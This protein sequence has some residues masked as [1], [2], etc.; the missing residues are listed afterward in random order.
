MSE[1]LNLARITKGLDNE[2]DLFKV[3][4]KL[5]DITKNLLTADRS[6]IFLYDSVN[7]E[8]FTY[9]AHGV[10]EIR[11]PAKGGISGHTFSSGETL[12]IPD[13]YKDKR[14]NKESDIK[15]GYRCKTILSMPIR[16]DDEIIGVFQVINKLDKESFNNE[17]IDLL[18]KFSSY[19]A[20][21]LNR[22]LAFKKSIQV[23]RKK[24]ANIGSILEKVDEDILR[25]IEST[26]VPVLISNDPESAD[27]YFPFPGLDVEIYRVENN[28]F[29]VQKDYRN[30]VLVD[31]FRLKKD[32]PVKILYNSSITINEYAI[33]YEQIKWYFKVKL[34]PYSPLT[35]Y[36][37]SY[38]NEIIIEKEDN[39]FT[40]ARIELSRSLIKI[41]PLKEQELYINRKKTA[42][43][44]YV[45]INDLISFNGK[46]LNLKKLIYEEL[47]EKEFL[48]FD[49]SQ[50]KF[51]ISNSTKAD[52]SLSDNLGIVWEGKLFK[53]D[54]E[55]YFDSGNCPFDIYVN[56]HKVKKSRIVQGD[57]LYLNNYVIIF[58][59]KHHL[60]EKSR[61]S[62]KTFL[63]NNISY[64]F[65]D[66]KP[67]VEK[68]KF[69]VE[70]NELVGVMGPSG[71]GK[72]TLFNI[73]N[74]HLTPTK[75][76]VLIDDQNFHENYNFLKNFM[77]FVPQDDLL[78]E[79]LTVYENLYYNAKLRFPDRSKNSLNLLIAQVL[80]DI[81]LE[82]KAT[83]KVGSPLDK[84][85]SG[86]ERKRLNIGL[87]L[88]SDSEIYF[89]D[90]PTSGLSSKDS[91]KIID[92]L[93]KISLN[94]KIVFVV[95][96]QPS[97]QLYKKFDKML[98]M[99]K[100]GKLVFFGDIYES[101]RYFRVHSS[102]SFSYSTECPVCKNVDPDLILETLEEPLREKDGTPLNERKYLPEY[103][104]KEYLNYEKKQGD[105]IIP[106]QETLFV[107]PKMKV[108]VFSKIIQ[109]STLFLRN[110][111]NKL[112]DRSNL[113]ITFLEAPVLALIVSVLL[114]FITGDN[115]T[116]YNNKYLST[117]IFLS[118]LVSVFLAMTNS[119]DEVIRDA[120]ILLR[121]KML[122]ITNFEYYIS[123]YCSLFIFSA[124]QNFIYLLISF[125]ILEIKE[126]FWSY[127]AILTVISMA[128]IS[129]GLFVSSIPNLTSKAAQ[130]IIPML[131]VP[132]IIFG[133]YLVSFK[134]MN[135]YVF[136]NK[137]NPIPEICQIM[138]SR[139]G[140]EAITILQDYYNSFHTRKDKLQNE[141]D[142]FINSR[143]KFI[144]KFSE[145]EYDLRKREYFKELN[146]FRKNYKKDYGNRNL[147]DLVSDG[148]EDFENI[149]DA[150]REEN[151]SVIENELEIV[152]PMFVIA[153]RIPFSNILINTAYY[154]SLV[155]LGFT[156]LLNI[157]AILMLIYRE[158]LIKI[159]KFISA[160]FSFK[161]NKLSA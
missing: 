146:N 111:K 119:V 43:D 23:D 47:I 7:D 28:Y 32:K 92:L 58:D 68:V 17:D 22:S 153:K 75:G 1:K 78:F 50:Q 67:G 152:Y 6:S 139:W 131:L 102:S 118:V 83:N 31:N 140:F 134:D 95:I 73:L 97:S 61:F 159:F 62:F 107:P 76:E 69:S 104:Q 143:D 60:F 64:D 35:L 96:H 137:K 65:G 85:L 128:G 16:T 71:C 147:H 106:G 116:L 160:N 33:N 4:I 122:N 113:I 77:G 80:K 94:D 115:Y 13:A 138:P 99:D 49:L 11:I 40:L 37:N 18:R 27:I 161:R 109:F 114:K 55:F 41:I 98:V 59:F 101:I 44:T 79:N 57:H 42:V 5:N 91:E 135:K 129:V 26:I 100:G 148:K 82:D 108:T 93:K 132:Q 54:D 51:T 110:F 8:L 20:P 156:F 36:V 120:A 141:L 87:E 74:G 30:S 145:D 10:G 39:L 127:F 90:E 72:S 70:H 144:S 21:I 136:I 12:N 81:G 117:Y 130:N 125:Q 158:G 38:E 29:I 84:H 105:V 63:V 103:W 123:K 19:V 52:I 155:L 9:I 14:F 34:N 3:L 157:L 53:D 150:L 88:L 89:L 25:E 133:G 56:D 48:Y 126:L 142:E 151:S 46:N 112:K 24:L 149:L 15:T 66:N 86:G 45:N 121:E 154:N 2:K 124:F